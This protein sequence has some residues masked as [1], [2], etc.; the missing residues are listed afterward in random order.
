[1]LGPDGEVIMTGNLKNPGGEDIEYQAPQTRVAVAR[2]R[3]AVAIWATETRTPVNAKDS[4][5]RWRVEVVSE[6]PVGAPPPEIEALVLTAASHIA[7]STKGAVKVPV[8]L[9]RL[10]ANA[11]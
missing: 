3:S 2:Q 8:P 11:P 7:S 4:G 10:T 9:V 1:M 5:E 6:L